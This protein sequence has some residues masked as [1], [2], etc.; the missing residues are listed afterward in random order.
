M[1]FLQMHFT[2]I[3]F[4]NISLKII[5]KLFRIVYNLFQ[6]QL[7]FVQTNAILHPS[8]IFFPFLYLSRSHP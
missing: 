4:L 1:L 3:Y 8:S 7:T 5:Y 6:F 2:Y